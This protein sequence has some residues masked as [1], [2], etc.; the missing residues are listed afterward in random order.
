[1]AAADLQTA[2]DRIDARIAEYVATANPSY[3]IDGESWQLTAYFEALCRQREVILKA[4][5]AAQGP[6]ET[7]S[8]G[9]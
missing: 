5:L 9:I 6:F 1:M 4:L 3:S 7:R 8:Q 2:L